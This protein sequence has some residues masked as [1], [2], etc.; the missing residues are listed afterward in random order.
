MKIV[1]IIIQAVFVALLLICALA[2]SPS[3]SSIIFL[4]AAVI[5]LPIKPFEEFLEKIKIKLGI[6][7]VVAVILAVIAFM[8]TPDK[9]PATAEREARE[10]N[11]SSSDDKDKNKDKKDDK[12]DNK[13]DDSRDSGNDDAAKQII[14]EWH[15]GDSVAID[16]YFDFAEDGTWTM[17]SQGGETGSG[18]YKIV[19][20]KKIELKGDYDGTVFTI[21][22]AEQLTDEEGMTLT[23][24][25]QNSHSDPGDNDDPADDDNGRTGSSGRSFGGDFTYHPVSEPP[26]L[27]NFKDIDKSVFA[28]SAYEI[29]SVVG[30]WY[31]DGWLEGYY[32]ELYGNGTWKYF[33]EEERCGT[34][35]IQNALFYLDECEYGASVA[36]LSIFYDE[37]FGTY[38]ASFTNTG[39]EIMLTRSPKSGKP[40][41]VMED[42]CK[43]C[44]DLDAFY[45][46]KYPLKELEGSWD[47]V[48][49]PEETHYFVITAEGIWSYVEDRGAVEVGLL[50]KPDDNGIYVS[51]GA[52]W[53]TIRKFKISDDGYLY[54]DGLPYEKRVEDAKVPPQ[55]TAGTYM[56]DDR[57]G[58]YIFYDDW[59][60]E[61]T[62]DSPFDEHGSYLFIG[63]SMLLY[64]EDGYR[65]HSFYQNEYMRTNERH[66][67]TNY[68]N[69]PYGEGLSFVE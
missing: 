58:G 26:K 48:E 54:I 65:I 34:Y 59:T 42:G 18:T 41:F 24:V 27:G 7:I 19:D 2:W 55:G 29:E 31:E 39:P 50:D 33:G 5:L 60:F 47:P 56:Y 22:N 68:E 14:G 38:S 45:E 9:A 3:L 62:Q 44:K 69:D 57:D 43:H 6:R 53:G 61:S 10:K 32:L 20:G 64:D 52:T 16:R 49:E 4:V 30:R 40:Y 17:S 28:E 35:T 13:K 15:Y 1:S 21:D 12:K 8:V 63:S 67:I 36:Q 23:R 25:D 66:Y 46:E 37:D 11:S 51:E